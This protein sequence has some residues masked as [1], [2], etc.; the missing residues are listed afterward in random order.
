ML[1]GWHRRFSLLSNESWGSPKR[2]GL[3]AALHPG[4]AC[5]GIAFRVADDDWPRTSAY[6]NRRERAYRHI[7][8]GLRCADGAVK[9][10]TFAFDPAHPRAVGNL[11]P[12]EAARLIAQGDGKNGTSRDYFFNT[13]AEILAMGTRPGAGLRALHAAVHVELAALSPGSRPRGARC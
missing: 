3:V 8:V 1:H 5:R 11:P 2:P 10:L 4:G 9:A 7:D 13:Y 6:L 12:R